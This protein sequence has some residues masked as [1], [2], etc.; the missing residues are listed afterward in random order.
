MTAKIYYNN[1]LI[2]NDSNFDN[3]PINIEAS[4]ALGLKHG[5]Q[6]FFV[7]HPL[8]ITASLILGE[9]EIFHLHWND[10]IIE[11]RKISNDYT[12][13]ACVIQTKGEYE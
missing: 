5:Q 7:K 1:A 3:V 11:L 9:K 12:F 8:F 13:E 4:D 10:M 2:L 6:F